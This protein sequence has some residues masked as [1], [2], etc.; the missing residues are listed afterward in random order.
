M[1]YAFAFPFLNIGM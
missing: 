1:H